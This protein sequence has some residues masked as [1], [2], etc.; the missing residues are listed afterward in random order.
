MIISI[1][2]AL[3]NMSFSVLQHMGLDICGHDPVN[4]FFF[5]KKMSKRF[6]R[7]FL[8]QLGSP[9]VIRQCTMLYQ[10]GSPYVFQ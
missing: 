7:N 1:I 4:S 8:G 2:K 6:F 9:I 3:G 10:L 5:G